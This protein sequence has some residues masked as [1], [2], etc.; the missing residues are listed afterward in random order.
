MKFVTISGSMYEVDLKEKK[1]RRLIGVN[2]PQPRQGKDGEWKAFVDI[3]PEVPVK[4]SPVIFVWD[5]A[6]TPKLEDTPE[7]GYIAP[8]TMTSYVV[9]IIEDEPS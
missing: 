3:L 7:E 8:T 2:D 6:T 5:R 4:G 1:C 9:E